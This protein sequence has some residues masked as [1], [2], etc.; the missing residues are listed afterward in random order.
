MRIPRKAESDAGYG[1]FDTGRWLGLQIPLPLAKKQGRP[2]A[3]L[4]S[5][6]GDEPYSVFERSGDRFAGRKRVKTGI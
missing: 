5:I 1:N 3:A 4:R 2:E 6:A